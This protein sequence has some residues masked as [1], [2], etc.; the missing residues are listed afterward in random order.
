MH[1]KIYLSPPHMSGREQHYISE[2]FRSN[3][4]APLGP[5]VNTFEEQLAERVG[6]K[7]AAAVSSGTAAIHLALRLLEVKEGDSVFC[8]SFTFVAT[9]NPILYEKAVPVFIDS[10]PD[11]WNM[12]PKA[13]ERALEDA[14]RNGKL[15]KAVIAVNLYGQSAKMDDIISLC[16]AYGVPVIEDAAESLGTVYK[17]KQSGTFGRFGIFS[18]NGNKIIT[19]SGGGMLVSDDEAAIEKARFLAS[20][21]REPAVHYQHSEIGHNYRLSNILA[22]VGIAQLEVLDERVEKRRAI[23]TRYKNALGHI[24]GVRFMPEYA[25]GVSNRWLTTLTLDNGLNP[26]DTVQRLAEENIEARPLW[27]P[28][29]TQPL[30]APSLF[31]SHEGNGSICEDLFKRGICLPSGSNLTEEEQD[32]VIDV[33]AHLFQT[34][35]VKKWT[36]SIR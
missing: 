17:G 4:I 1:K 29:H 28:L 25:A 8:Q 10:E 18:F 34:A 15:P 27:K 22:G 36:A 11:T 9:A 26:Y 21:A 6:V 12:S 23:F 3:W 7:G 30:F 31:Y 5:L 2:A 33:L 14:K 13:L 19:T 24:D 20:Q 16:D 32:R 35:E